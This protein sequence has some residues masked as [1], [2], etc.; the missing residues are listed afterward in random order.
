MNPPRFR[1][2][3]AGV[4]LMLLFDSADITWW[5]PAVETTWQVQY[6]GTLNTNVVVQMYDLDMFDAT[7][8][9]VASLRA[10]G[11]TV[12]GYINMGAWEDW[13]PD[14]DAFPPEVLGKDYTG[15]PGEKW[16]DIRRLDLLAPILRARMDLARSKGFEGIDPDNVNGYEN[17]TGFPLTAADQLAFNKWLAAEA[18]QRGLAI[19]LKNDADQ[20]AALVAHFDWIITE[21]CF[22]E[23]WYDTVK[24][25]ISAGK[26]VFA[27]EYTDQTTLDA[28]CARAT[29]LRFS[30]ILKNRTLDAYRSACPPPAYWQNR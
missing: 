20:A 1:L 18:H 14:K 25:F 7:A 28:F 16:L 27:I 2:A 13:R 6:T 11:R 4:P 10:A 17:D 8:A 19:G 22:Y 12:V 24:V 21:S 26:P 30:A 3:I 15:W 5:K 29:A 23:G 9:Q